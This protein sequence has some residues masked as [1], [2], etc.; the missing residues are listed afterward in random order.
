MKT[1][2]SI[3]DEIYEAA[4]AAAERLGISRSRFYANAVAEHVQKYGSDGVTEK[5]DEVYADRPS[6]L[7]P[8]LQRMQ[9]SSVAEED[10]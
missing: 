9:R 5:L 3:P 10:W 8:A 7:D 2:I 6:T 4:E 1:A